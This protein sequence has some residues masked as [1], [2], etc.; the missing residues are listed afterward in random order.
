MIGQRKFHEASVL[1]IRQ[2]E[3]EAVHI[4]LTVFHIVNRVVLIELTDEDKKPLNIC[5]KREQDLLAEINA[6]FN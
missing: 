6:S 5:R 1:V 2:Q 3:A 4:T